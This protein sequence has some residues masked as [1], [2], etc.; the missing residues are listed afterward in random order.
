MR[1]RKKAIP[2]GVDAVICSEV[3]EHLQEPEEFIKKIN[4]SLNMGG[5]LLLST[6]NARNWVKYPLFFLKNQ[7]GKKSEERLKKELTKKEGKYKL[8]EEEQHLHV[9]GQD[10]LVG[11]LKKSGFDVYKIKRCTTFFGG[12]FLDRHPLLLGSTMVFDSIMNLLGMTRIGWDNLVFARK[13][14]A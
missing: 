11:L 6:P 7:I 8:A 13:I 12:P 3:L 2:K 14:G 4:R 10:E 9:Y 1:Y 5:Y